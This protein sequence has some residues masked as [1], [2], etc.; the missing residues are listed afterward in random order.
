MRF[1]GKINFT[2][3]Y[4][5]YFFFVSGHISLR[6]VVDRILRDDMY[7]SDNLGNV[8]EFLKEMLEM[9][10]YETTLMKSTTQAIH[11]DIHAQQ[12]QLQAESRRGLAVHTLGK[13]YKKKY[14][15][16]CLF[17]SCLEGEIHT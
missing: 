4:I 1:H 2:K 10:H 12:L 13:Q 11:S 7:Q 16:F 3:K 8:Q 14:S 6:S 17:Y 5:T 9:Y 15:L